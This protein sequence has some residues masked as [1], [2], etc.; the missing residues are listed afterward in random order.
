M[1]TPEYYIESI[2]GDVEPEVGDRKTVDLAIQFQIK[3]AE[4]EDEDKRFVN[5]DLDMMLELFEYEKEDIYD[6]PEYGQI[7]IGFV[8]R[9][10]KNEADPEFEEKIDEEVWRWDDVGYEQINKDLRTA[11]ESEIVPQIF[12]PLDQLF[13][14][15][16]SGILPRVRFSMQSSAG[17]ESDEKSSDD[18]DGE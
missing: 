11:I 15:D 13:R 10:D 3:K 12:R 18:Q 14:A 7:S 8:A 5:F 16:F 2:E 6:D 17:E 4:F 1:I 9:I